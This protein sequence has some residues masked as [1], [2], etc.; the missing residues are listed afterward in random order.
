MIRS[1]L[2]TGDSMILKMISEEKK[3]QKA[4][5]NPDKSVIALIKRKSEKTE[6]GEI[7]ED[8]TYHLFLYIP[9]E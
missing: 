7:E 8:T 5:F 4:Q 9:K 3:I 2:T 1:G 6:D